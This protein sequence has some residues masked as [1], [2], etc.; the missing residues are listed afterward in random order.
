MVAAM[1][2][3]T[4]GFAAGESASVDAEG[5][6]DRPA[7]AQRGAGG[8]VRGREGGATDGR[9]ESERKGKNLETGSGD[10][11]V[12]GVMHCSGRGANME[13]RLHDR[14]AGNN[15]GDVDAVRGGQSNLL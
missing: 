15:S 4:A 13:R 11:C 5:R 3:T 2:S 6:A 9:G 8:R 12:A 7:V 1:G 14:T 10:V